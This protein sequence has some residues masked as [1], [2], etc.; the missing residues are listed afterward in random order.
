LCKFD[1]LLLR[2]TKSVAKG[3]AAAKYIKDIDTRVYARHAFPFPRMSRVTSNPC[4]QAN[5]GLLRVRE[6]AP[7]KLLVELWYYCQDKF[8]QRKIQANRGNSPFTEVALRRHEENLA[9]FGQWQV[10]YGEY[11]KFTYLIFNLNFSNSFLY[12]ISFALE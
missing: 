4:E 9:S 12:S 6:F 7:F 10:M 3:E 8:F 2:L 1:D 5:S 11:S